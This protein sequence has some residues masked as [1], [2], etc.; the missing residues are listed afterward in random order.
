MNAHIIVMG[1]SGCGK[2]TVGHALAQ[3]LNRP[4]IEGDKFHPADNI[5][6][7][8]GG[9][10][11]D[12]LD[13]RAWINALC[14]A[15]ND[16]PPAVIS[17]SALNRSVRDWL[18]EG[19]NRSLVFIHLHGTEAVIAERLAAREN[20]FFDPALLASQFAALECPDDAILIS[21]EQDVDAIVSACVKGL[22]KQR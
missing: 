2:S 14:D 6:K 13:R 10:P 5:A 8:Q 16:S 1:V 3:R 12:N 21:I 4:F 15:A 7:M 9:E 18:Y 11:L 20:H 19:V 22:D 17:C